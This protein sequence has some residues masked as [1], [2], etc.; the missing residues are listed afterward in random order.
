[1]K[2]ILE[3][4]GISK[5]FLIGSQKLPYLNFRDKIFTAFKR[6]KSSQE[7]WALQDVSFEVRKGESIGI[8]GR[9]GAGKSTLL[10]ILSRITPPTQG[11]IKV[12]GRIASLLEVG[13][14][15]HQ[16]LTGRENIF[17]N[18]SILGM[19]NA[20]IKSRFDEIVDFSGTE[21]FLDT[22]IKHYSSGMQLRLA[23]AV[24][25]HLEPEILIVDEV[26]AVGDAEFQ[27]KCLKKME[28]VTGHGKTILFVSH[29]MDA[30]STLC[31][32]G[33]LLKGGRVE[34]SGAIQDVVK[35]Y[36]LEM[37]RNT[38]SMEEGIVKF[39]DIQQVKDSLHLVVKFSGD[40]E[41]DYPNLGF[42][43]Q[44][45]YG[46]AV[47]GTNPLKSEIE[48]PQ[49]RGAREGTIEVVINS[50]KLARGTYQLLVWFG[51]RKGNLFETKDPLQFQVDGMAAEQNRNPRFDG[52]VL[53]QCEWNIR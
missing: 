24:A 4:N 31:K 22:P 39:I 28:D 2:P 52:F 1:M 21:K 11:T 15:F 44:D 18:G 46:H 50:P 9:N 7:F 40:V 16:E 33:V 25:A 29:N 34:T 12:R 51:N 48:F 20:E 32:H 35:K 53:P 3:V 47:T 14:G 30:I 43:I 13:T 36:L 17:M 8:I 45:I 5:K 37:D 10:K 23:F 38:L 6:S 26:L 49:F 27:K 19:K 42:S 41:I